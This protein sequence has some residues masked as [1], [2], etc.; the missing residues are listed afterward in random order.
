MDL[1]DASLVVAASRKRWMKHEIWMMDVH[2]SCKVHM[3][4]FGKRMVRN[5]KEVA[6]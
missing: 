5:G 1:A 6:A 4:D 2:I 3:R